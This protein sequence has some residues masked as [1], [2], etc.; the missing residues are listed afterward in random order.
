MQT[1][2][3]ARTVTLSWKEGEGSR[4][5]DLGMCEDKNP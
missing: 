1:G 5:G 4:E 3:V 2:R